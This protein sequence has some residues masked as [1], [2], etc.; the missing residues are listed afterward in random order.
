MLDRHE[1][2][3]DW[4]YRPHW[5][6]LRIGAARDGNLTAISSLS[7]GCAGVGLGAGVGYVA[8]GALYVR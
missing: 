6:R 2:Q 3:I 4:G 7:Y 5:Q 8:A 1:E